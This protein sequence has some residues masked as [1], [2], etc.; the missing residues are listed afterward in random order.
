MSKPID[1]SRFDGIGDSDSESEDGLHQM[2]SPK[3]L[4][5]PSRSQ[6]ARNNHGKYTNKNK[7]AKSPQPIHQAKTQKDSKTG[8]YI[9]Q[10]NNRKIYEW[11]QNLEEVNIYIDVPPHLQSPK[12]DTFQINI[13][14]SRLQVGIQSHDR[15]FINE[16]TFDKVV[17]KESCWYLDETDM[18]QESECG[19]LVPLVQIHIVLMK[20][21]RGQVWDA[22]L[23]SANEGGVGSSSVVDPS[24]MEEIRRDMMLERFQEENPSFDFRNA[25]FNGEVP[26]PREFMG[27][28]QYR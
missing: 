18:K 4:P 21:H 1:Y 20:A 14:P 28:V 3:I 12:R 25:K 6:H 13:H 10:Y 24:T 15:F 11:D 16:P 23:I 8:R 2:T 22:P 5:A 9:F 19:A 26:N 17:T 27:G 7:M